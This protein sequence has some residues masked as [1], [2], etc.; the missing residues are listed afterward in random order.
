MS[1]ELLTG[2]ENQRQHLFKGLVVSNNFLSIFLVYIYEIK[3]IKEQLKCGGLQTVKQQA[4]VEKT[5]CCS[6]IAFNPKFYKWVGMWEELLMAK[7]E[8]TEER[9]FE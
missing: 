4:P 8:K 1:C 7:W 2:K 5:L 9:K 3:C 6:K